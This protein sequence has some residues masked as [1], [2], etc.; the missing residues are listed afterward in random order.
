MTSHLTIRC[1]QE[2]I[3]KVLVGGVILNQFELEY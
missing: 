2:R 1:I 3:K